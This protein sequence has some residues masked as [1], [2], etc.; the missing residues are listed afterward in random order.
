[1]INSPIESKEVINYETVY[2]PD[3]KRNTLCVSSQCGC[4]LNCKFCFTGKQKF[5]KNLTSTEILGQ[6]FL[7]NQNTKLPPNNIV[8]MGQGEPVFLKIK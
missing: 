2:I 8:F 4:S 7:S 3:I 6:L 5:L 1:L